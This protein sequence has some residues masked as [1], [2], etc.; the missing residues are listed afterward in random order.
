MVVFFA[1]LVHE[2]HW[3]WLYRVLHGRKERL[4][5]FFDADCGVCFLTVRV[6]A[7][8][9]AYERIRFVPNHEQGVL[10]QGVSQELVERTVVVQEE[11]TGRISTRSDAVAEVCRALPLGFLPYA[12]L[13]LPGLRALWLRLYEL[14]AKNRTAISQWLG[15]A[16]CGV[17]TEPGLAAP[18]PQ[19]NG[20]A[21]LRARA[22]SV[23]NQALVAV[24]LVAATGETLTYNESVPSALHY[25]QP[26]VLQAII[27]YGRLIQSWRMFA[28]EAPEQDIMISVEA[29][30][31]DGRLVDPY[32]EVASRVKRPPFRGVPPRLGN[33]QFFTTYSL[34]IPAERSRAYWGAFEQWILSYH[35]RTKNPKDRITGYTAYVVSDLS[36]SVGKR[37]PSA[38]KKEP[39]MSYPGPR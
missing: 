15:L 7:R 33:D 1:L 3:A 23:L 39:F 25:P 27:D 34:V 22:F 13:K 29:T 37:R 14:V 5:C 11:S 16:A 8:L 31:V 6:L 32:N 28:P 10:P 18:Q 26:D 38:P 4:L 21:R 36:P 17:P 24:L 35:L 2:R 30:T 20:P 12:I 9:D 19:A